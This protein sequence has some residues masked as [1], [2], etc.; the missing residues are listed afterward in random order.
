MKIFEICLSCFGDSLEHGPG[1]QV[2]Y[3]LTCLQ[4]SPLHLWLYHEIPLYVVERGRVSV[5]I[6]DQG[7]QME[8]WW[9]GRSPA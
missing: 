7:V 5:R 3:S 2:I 1:L 4:F 6:N 9:V 8:I